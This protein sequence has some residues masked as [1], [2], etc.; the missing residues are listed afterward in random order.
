MLKIRGRLDLLHEPLGAQDGG[1]FRT[2]DLDGDLAVVF[3][4]FREVH[5]RHA[6][7]AEL[8]LD[9]VAVGEGGGETG[10]LVVQ[11]PTCPLNSSNKPCTRM[12]SLVPPLRLII[13]KR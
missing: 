8:A 3:E 12:S 9:G 10:E 6:A 7:G 13:K 2:Q 11:F 1:E 5:G 4:I